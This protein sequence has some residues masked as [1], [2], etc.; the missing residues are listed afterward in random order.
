MIPFKMNF[1][2][3]VLRYENAILFY[4]SHSVCDKTEVASIHTKAK[5]AS[6][7]ESNLLANQ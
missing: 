5:D 6:N 4:F 7:I 1:R 3:K 2:T